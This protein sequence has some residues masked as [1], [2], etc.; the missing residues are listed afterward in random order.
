LG[1]GK[2]VKRWW[3]VNG[4]WWMERIKEKDKEKDAG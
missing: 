1:A 3:M 4:G 2:R